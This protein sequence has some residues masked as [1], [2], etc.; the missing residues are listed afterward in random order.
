MN[1]WLLFKNLLWAQTAIRSSTGTECQ[2]CRPAVDAW[3]DQWALPA[4][5]TP[6]QP[7]ICAPAGLTDT[8]QGPPPEQ[9]GHKET[10]AA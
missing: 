7:L 2:R 5:L 1:L 9:T 3:P 10:P 4:L 6:R 8:L